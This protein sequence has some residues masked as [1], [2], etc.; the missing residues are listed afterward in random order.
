MENNNIQENDQTLQQSVQPASYSWDQTAGSSADIAQDPV[1]MRR[2]IK[3]GYGWASLSMVF[4]YIFI[5]I[6]AVA[7]SIIYS[8]VRTVNFMQENPGASQAQLMEFTTDMAQ[9]VATNGRYLMIVNAVAYLIANISAFA[10]GISAVKAFKAKSIFKKSRLG[11]G[12]IALAAFAALG[13]QAASMFL[14]QIMTMITGVTGMDP[15]QSSMMSMSG[16]TFLNI[17]MLLYFVIIAPVTEELLCRGFV[18]NVLSPVNRTFALIASSILFG[19]MHGNF[20]QM[21]NGFLLGLIL[22]YIALKS[23]S[24]LSSIILH[25]ILNA[26]AMF[27]S[28][29]YE[30]KLLEA[31]GEETAA[32]VEIAHFAVL[33]VIGI[34]ALVVLLKR[35][36]KILPGDTIVPE[37]SYETEP[38]DEKKLTWGLLV[39]CPSVWVVAVFYIGYAILSVTAI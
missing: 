20:N 30:Y 10:I 32:M 5:I 15:E 21:F 29:V 26:N 27:C 6:V 17:V 8:S 33:L 14:Q 12:T 19:L 38:A 4:Q 16:D 31:S 3:S 11:A 28:Y 2:K 1:M 7:A 9:S 37:Y 36:G 34:A 25:M 23:G 18:M 22:G 13:I 35:N 24:V 39:K